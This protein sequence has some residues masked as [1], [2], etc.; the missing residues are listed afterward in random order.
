MSPIAIRSRRATP[1]ARVAPLA[2]L[3]LAALVLACGAPAPEFDLV[4]RGGTLVDGS[5]EPATVG[6]LAIDGDRIV[7]LGDLGGARG[8]LELDVT[9]LAVAPGFVNM[10]SWA[11]ESLIE[12][13]RSQS[14]IRQGV[15]LEVM[16]EGTS[17]GPLDGTMRARMLERQSDIRYPIEW[18]KLDGYLRFLEERGVST[19]VASFVGAGTVRELVV[20]AE[21]RTATPEELERMR[22][23]VRQA[24]E[25]GAL[26]VASSLIYPP[27]S[28]ADTAELIA[29]AE[30]AAEHDG[31]YASHL[32]NEGGQLLAAI[33]ELI[34]IARATGI[35]AEIYHLKAAGVSHW[36]LLDEAIAKIEA[37]RAEGLA[38]T[39][40]VYTYPASST[41]LNTIMPPWVQEG[42]FDASLERLRDPATRQRIAAEML[43]DSTEWENMWLGAGTPEN[44]LLVGFRN[45]ELRHLTG[46][47]LAAVAVERGGDPRFVAMDLIVE[48]GSRIQVV[49]FSMSPDNLAKKVA[50][51]WVSFCSDAASLAPEGVFLES[52]TH[53][54]AYGSFAR[55]L[56][57]FV[58]DDGVL[59]L[60]EAVR[61]LAALPA[62]TLGVE[63]R[64]RLAASYYADVAVFDLATIQDHATFEQPHQYAT[65]MVHVFVN[66]V[67]VLR[68]GAHTGAK[69]GRVVRGSGWKGGDDP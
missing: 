26:G 43:V 30:V 15:T 11:N 5:G 8:R 63:G 25:E 55:V 64:G 52:S 53:P 33:D 59:T 35:R 20:G 42:G 16:G 1:R 27:G 51:P 68:D 40:D 22:G 58:R 7:A 4:L 46:K 37:A 6:D 44:I 45:P 9:G 3:V 17:M 66:G 61:K 47:T 10:M 65:G 14:D 57:K 60:E 34:A 32:R 31:L 38:I 24:M 48:D 69:P 12:D 62:E 50:L 13:G 39:A 29:L 2:A 23:L 49:F 41:G 21:D 67:H 54:R 18:T 36:H 56:G 28:F 19:N